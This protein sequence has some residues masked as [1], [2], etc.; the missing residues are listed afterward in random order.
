MKDVK[1]IAKLFSLSICFINAIGLVRMS[2]SERFTK[3]FYELAH[4]QMTK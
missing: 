3:T 4:Y 2:S 1:K